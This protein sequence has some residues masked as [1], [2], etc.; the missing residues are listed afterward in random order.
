M[1]KMY[2]WNQ[3]PREEVREGVERCGFRGQDAILVMN[4]I[5]PG[6]TVRPHSHKFEQIVVCIRGEF[7]YHVG[8]ETFHM[9]AGSMLR[10]PP[11][12]EHYVEPIGS[13]VALNLDIFSPVRE[14]YLHLVEY[15]VN[16]FSGEIVR[17]PDV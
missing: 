3:L 10:V 2:N 12:T 13:E 11:N 1:S 14:D 8:E 16:E 17:L 5:S 6:M 7:A 4:W 9:T 15:Q